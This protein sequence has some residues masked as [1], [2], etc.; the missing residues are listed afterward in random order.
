MKKKTH[1]LIDLIKSIYSAVRAK[2]NN[3]ASRE[4]GFVGVGLLLFFYLQLDDNIASRSSIA[5]QSF[6]IFQ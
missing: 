4:F 5:W 3:H 1:N 6:N 2:N